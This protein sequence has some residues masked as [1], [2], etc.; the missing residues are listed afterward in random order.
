MGDFANVK[1]TGYGA[2]DLHGEIV[3]S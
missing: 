2:Y 3:A 1:I